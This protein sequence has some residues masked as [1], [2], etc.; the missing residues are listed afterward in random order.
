MKKKLTCALAIVLSISMLAGC[1]SKANEKSSKKTSKVTVDITEVMENAAESMADIDTIELGIN[2]DIDVSG[3]M[4]GAEVSIKGSAKMQGVAS[5]YEPAFEAKGSVSYEVNAAGTK[6][7][8][9]Y[10]AE[11]YGET[12]DEEMN[13]YVKTN[14]SEWLTDSIDVSE[15]IET[16]EQAKE[17]LGDMN[18]AD[19]FEEIDEED[20]KALEEYMKLES[21]TQI[22]NKK[23]CYVISADID[24]DKFAELS[25]F[26]DEQYDEFVEEFKDINF[27]YGFCFEKDT[28][29]PVQVYVDMKATVNADGT[30]VEINKLRLEMNM[31]VNASKV[32]SVPKDVKKDAVET[33]LGLNGADITGPFTDIDDGDGWFDDD[34]ERTTDDNDDDDE[35]T[36]DDD[37]KN[38]SNTS[39]SSGIDLSSEDYGKVSSDKIPKT[40]KIDGQ[41]IS[42]PCKVSDINVSGYVIDE[43][44]SGSEI[45]PDSTESVYFCDENDSSKYFYVSATNTGTSSISV[46]DGTIISIQVDDSVGVEC[47]LSNGIKL[48]DDASVI[49]KEYQGLKPSYTYEGSAMDSAEFADEDYNSISYDWD[50]EDNKIIR[51]EIFYY[52]Y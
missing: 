3:E 45:E 47:E 21:K 32:S 48:G 6:M 25:E 27:S 7:S 34:D 42:L 12:E 8:G 5:I 37:K 43:S 36:T 16:M 15:Y 31:D 2:G 39:S 1:G 11:A 23:E 19:A 14:D 33:D 4:E 41:E 9:D 10:K 51:F 29:M 22:V 20:M 50:K 24:K 46:K 26:T 13:I 30:E 44:R 40:L 52:E 28:Y 17:S 35:R 49:G 18:W 38:Q